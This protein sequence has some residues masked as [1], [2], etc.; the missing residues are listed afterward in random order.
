[1]TLGQLALQYMLKELGHGESG[2]NNWGPDLER[3]GMGK[4][5]NGTAW[6]AKLCSYALAQAA[7]EL[8]IERVKYSSGARRLGEYAS[9]HPGA[10]V[11]KKQDELQPGDLVVN[12]RGAVRANL[13]HVYF[14][15]QNVGHG[16]L[17]IEGNVGIFPSKVAPYFHQFPIPEF[18][19]GV[20]LA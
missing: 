12:R 11:I 20:R 9:A 2:R 15:L 8:G 16:I 4:T 3:Y 13:G 6:C 7:D 17:S 18:L 10:K 14:T 19:Y 1:M 5:K